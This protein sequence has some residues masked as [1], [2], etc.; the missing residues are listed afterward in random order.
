MLILDN[1][2]WHPN[3]VSFLQDK[4]GW[5][6]IDFHRF[7]RIIK[8]TW[9]ISLFINQNGYQE[10]IY[11]SNLNSKCGLKHVAYGDY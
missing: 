9:L 2:D 1:S 8:Y 4:L 5:M 7:G 10:P 11:K 6:Q 3:S